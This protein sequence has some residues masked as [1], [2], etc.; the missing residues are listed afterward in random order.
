MA[1]LGQLQR[2]AGGDDGGAATVLVVVFPE[3]LDGAV[4]VF[5]TRPLDVYLSLALVSRYT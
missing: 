1:Q 5:D 2:L 3:V 4:V